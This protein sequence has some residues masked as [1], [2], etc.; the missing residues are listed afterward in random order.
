[1]NFSQ[2]LRGS[3]ENLNFTYSE[4]DHYIEIKYSNIFDFQKIM[5]LPRDFEN[6]KSNTFFFN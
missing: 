3:I 5:H 2:F 6:V 1:M 4:T